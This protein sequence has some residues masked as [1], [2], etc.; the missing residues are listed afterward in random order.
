M[1]VRTNRRLFLKLSFFSFLQKKR[2]R[3]L[4]PDTEGVNPLYLSVHTL[5]NFLISIQIN[6]LLFIYKFFMVLFR[7]QCGSRDC[8]VRIFGPVFLACMG[9]STTEC[10]PFFV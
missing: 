5:L 10:G 3:L 1:E 7:L 9:A 4:Q 2:G 6:K 8:C